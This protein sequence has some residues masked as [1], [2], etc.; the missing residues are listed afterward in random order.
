MFD[1][2]P[3]LERQFTP[4]VIAGM[5]AHADR[6]PMVYRTDAF[7]KA[8]WPINWR[9]AGPEWNPT[10][11]GAFSIGNI[12]KLRALLRE[13][14][15][16]DERVDLYLRGLGGDT[17]PLD[18]P[19]VRGVR[20]SLMVTGHEGRHRSR[21]MAAEGMPLSVLLMKP[22]K[23]AMTHIG[24]RSPV[25]N[26]LY[27]DGPGPGPWLGD[28]KKRGLKPKDYASP[29][30][31]IFEGK[32]I[33]GKASGGAV[34]RIGE[35]VA[36]KLQ[37]GAPLRALGEKNPRDDVRRA[38]SAQPLALRRD[39]A[40]LLRE[41]I[42]SA[43]LAMRVPSDVVE[44]IIRSGELK[45]QFE[46]GTSKGTLSPNYRARA[47]RD[48]FGYPNLEGMGGRE[49]NNPTI[50]KQRPKYAYLSNVESADDDPHQSVRAYG[51]IKLLF[52]ADALRPRTTFTVGDSLDSDTI[53]APV[54][55]PRLSA[56]HPADLPW[57][58]I[59]S[60]ARR[61][62]PSSL[63]NV[64][65]DLSS[66]PPFD[67]GYIEAQIHG[68]LPL[69][70][71]RGATRGKPRDRWYIEHGVDDVDKRALDM[72]REYGIT[73]FSGGGA[74]KGPL[75][76]ALAY[77]SDNTLTANIRPA[78]RR[79]EEAFARV[80]NL[81]KQYTPEALGL[82]A[83][84]SDTLLIPY[85]PEMFEKLAAPLHFRHEPFDA[86]SDYSKQNVEKL[87][88]LMQEGVA[89]DRVPEFD[90]TEYSTPRS[91]ANMVVTGHE[92]RHRSRA[93]TQLGIPTSL[94]RV[95][96]ESMK[97]R[98][99]LRLA[100][101]LE[102][103]I[104]NERIPEWATQY[105]AI[106]EGKP[107]TGRAK[108]GRMQKR[109]G[110]GLMQKLKA[111]PLTRR[112]DELTRHP[113]KD[114]SKETAL[115]AELRSEASP[116]A[117]YGGMPDMGKGRGMGMG[118][119]DPARRKFLSFDT[120][121]PNE[122]GH[123]TQVG[124]HVMLMGDKQFLPKAW[125]DIEIEKA[126]RGQGYG[127]EALALALSHLK[128]ENARFDMY[129]VQPKAKKV[130]E[131]MGAKM[132]DPSKPFRHKTK[133]NYDED[134]LFESQVVRNNDYYITP[135]DFLSSFNKGGKADRYAGGGL[136]TSPLTMMKMGMN[137]LTRPF[138]RAMAKPVM[139]AEASVSGSTAAESMPQRYE[140]AKRS[141]Q[142][143]SPYAS[144]PHKEGQGAW[145][146]PEGLQTN[147][148]FMTELPPTLGRI[149]PS[150]LQHGEPEK[151]KFAA[152]MGKALNQ[153][154]VPVTRATKSL[155]N[156]PEGADAIILSDVTDADIRSLAQELGQDTV[157]SA[158]P[159]GEAV[160]FS[161]TGAP[162]AELAKSARMAAPSA[163]LNFGVSKPGVDRSIVTRTDWG[164]GQT[165]DKAGGE[166][167]LRRAE[168]LRASQRGIPQLP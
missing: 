62:T 168:A 118:F 49:P 23:D 85:R 121:R 76:K 147:P 106:F 10:D 13:G 79:L 70:L 48:M 18:V 146:G 20:P 145:M 94:V 136:I 160:I 150:L 40:S 141:L 93:M 137:M 151:M 58:N 31:S 66:A 108:G 87:K 68:P 114:V 86:I 135:L 2:V 97:V 144:L 140:S 96:P 22:E 67:P 35:S 139:G 148:L 16:F 73:T 69:S 98:R 12:E 53:P 45:N 15:P 165:Y 46:T 4:D 38:W 142:G 116:L 163:R 19:L 113:L 63:W 166:D 156:I 132:K 157:V 56:M 101:P 21:A 72:L 77:L 9:G 154:A 123:A 90:I 39:T 102:P 104:R 82:A 17:M 57:E 8:A 3:D 99:D 115:L 27:S 131:A 78:Q 110:G 37:R 125:V 36:S 92:G 80:P 117:F 100:G 28:L 1:R 103:V 122:T 133:I 84:N 26:Q 152:A 134:G 89:M 138:A 64:S 74:V 33:T 14:V 6:V 126:L 143:A 149:E 111:L 105:S 95:K 167:L 59:L 159:N 5:A 88:S 60:R 81:E 44:E 120:S 129:D 61:V 164:V 107:I 43:H 52:D 42:P 55:K 112:F 54:L 65:D 155:F 162:I 161:L 24:A 109:A 75:A 83:R 124:E 130:W 29:Y 32:P 34:R 119:R 7:E 153:E 71:V 158:R 47:E 50:F 25:L 30:E 11:I 41:E 128:D 91:I 127:R 51:L